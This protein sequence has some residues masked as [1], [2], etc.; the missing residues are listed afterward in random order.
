MNKNEKYQPLIERTKEIKKL[1]VEIQSKEVLKRIPFEL[2]FP[3]QDLSDLTPADKV[4]DRVARRIGIY[5]DSLECDL[6]NLNL[7]LEHA[8]HLAVLSGMEKKE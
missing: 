1:V 2:S 4:A 3:E 7:E 6:A 5:L 8:N